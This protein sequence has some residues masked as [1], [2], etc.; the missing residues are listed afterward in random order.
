MRKKLIICIFLLMYPVFLSASDESKRNDV[1]KL[2]SLM[3]ASSII[4]T[5]YS[6]VNQMIQSMGQQ[7]G[8][9][10]SERETF[11]KYMSKMLAMMKEEMSWEK[12]KAP[13]IE[14]Y[15]THYS[16]KEI[17]DMITF[18]ETETGKS[19]LKKMPAVMKDSMYISQSMMEEFIPKLQKVAQAFKEELKAERNK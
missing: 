16:E 1:E 18:Y 7:L 19:I 13:M 11:D 12:M 9:Q 14:I 3:N 17:R 5:M 10:P 2:L 4:D 15:I 8:V 6:Q